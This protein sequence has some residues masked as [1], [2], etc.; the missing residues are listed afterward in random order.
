LTSRMFFRPSGQTLHPS[1]ALTVP[2]PV[3]CWPTSV[4]TQ[5][6][7]V[8]RKDGESSRAHAGVERESVAIGSQTRPHCTMRPLRR[9]LR[10]ALVS[11]FA[12]SSRLESERPNPL[13]LTSGGTEQWRGDRV[14]RPTLCSKHATRVGAFAVLIIEYRPRAA[15][16]LRTTALSTVKRGFFARSLRWPRGLKRQ[17]DK[18]GLPVAAGTT[19]EHLFAIAFSKF[20][21]GR[22]TR[23]LH[24][25]CSFTL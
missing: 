3:C 19:S 10:R 23:K 5:F 13:K 1:T 9:T 6:R 12:E 2:F 22:T 15:R 16:S 24:G 7:L 18:L 4:A 14:P 20:C 25:D 21:E 11:G 8:V 17:L